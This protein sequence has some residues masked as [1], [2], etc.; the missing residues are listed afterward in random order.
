[1]ERK[2]QLQEQD[3]VEAVQL[4]QPVQLRRLQPRRVAEDQAQ[5]LQLPRKERDV[6]KE[7]QRR[8][9]SLI[10]R[11][12]WNWTIMRANQKLSKILMRNQLLLHLPSKLVVDLALRLPALA[13]ILSRKVLALQL[14]RRVEDVQPRRSLSLLHSKQ[15][16]TMLPK[17]RTL[18]PSP[19]KPMPN[20]NRPPNCK[21]NHFSDG[22]LSIFKLLI[23][24]FCYFSVI[25]FI[26][27][28]ML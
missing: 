22:S 20:W 28:P 21:T 25:F 9:T 17:R 24:L 4:A 19:I 7:K 3:V 8:M 23:L 10:M 16:T 14:E 13:K 12:N 1:V 26:L 11:K 15:T 6:A 27:I 5:E 2:L 18:K